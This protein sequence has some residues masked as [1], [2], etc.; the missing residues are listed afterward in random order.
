MDAPIPYNASVL[1]FM[2]GRRAGSAA[3]LDR[4]LASRP[5]ST[6]A[7]HHVKVICHR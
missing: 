5:R 4:L 2:N 6:N 3:C 7:H 1:C